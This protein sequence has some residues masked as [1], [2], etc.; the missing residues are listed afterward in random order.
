[1]TVQITIGILPLHIE[2][3]KYR[4]VKVEE[5]VCHVCKNGDVENEFHFIL[6][7]NAYTTLRNTMYDTIND[8]TF[9]R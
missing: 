8:V 4:N 7:C 5:R 9:Y 2:T 6:I 1:M 3:G